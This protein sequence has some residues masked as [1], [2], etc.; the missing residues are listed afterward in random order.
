MGGVYKKSN[1]RR[2]YFSYKRDYT[3]NGVRYNDNWNFEYSLQYTTGVLSWSVAT[4]NR[5]SADDWEIL[6]SGAFR[7]LF[8]LFCA[9]DTQ[10]KLGW[11]YS[12]VKAVLDKAHYACEQAGGASGVAYKKSKNSNNSGFY[13][14]GTINYG[15]G[16]ANFTSSFNSFVN[17]PSAAANMALPTIPS[18]TT[19]GYLQRLSSETAAL[20]RQT[21]ILS[22]NSALD[23]NL[24]KAKKNLLTDFII[25]NAYAIYGGGDYYGK[26][27]AGSETFYP[28]I[29]Y[30]ST[31]GLLGNRVGD[32]ES[33]EIDDMI[34]SRFG[35]SRAG[36]LGN[37]WYNKKIYGEQLIKSYPTPFSEGEILKQK[38]YATIARINAGFDAL[39]DSW[40][41]MTN[42]SKVG[43]W[44]ASSLTN[45]HRDRLEYKQHWDGRNG[46]GED[47]KSKEAI[48]ITYAYFYWSMGNT[49]QTAYD[50]I[51]KEQTERIKRQMISAD[52]LNKMKC[53]NYNLRA[54]L[55]F[56]KMSDID[57][58][59][60]E[61]SGK[62]ITWNIPNSP[63]DRGYEDLVVD[64]SL[65]KGERFTLYLSQLIYQK[66]YKLYVLSKTNHIFVDIYK[67]PSTETQD[68][69]DET[70]G[71]TD[72]STDTSKE[73]SE[74]QGTQTSGG[75]TQET[76][77][78]GIQDGDLIARLDENGELM[79]AGSLD[80]YDFADFNK[81]FNHQKTYT[82]AEILKIYN[83]VFLANLTQTKIWKDENTELSPCSL[84]ITDESYIYLRQLRYDEFMSEIYL[85]DDLKDFDDYENIEI[86]ATDFDFEI[87]K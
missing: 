57:N 45:K 53:Y 11:S 35:Q 13:V 49:M 22:V 79:L 48:G 73:T 47:K 41:E 28:Q 19:N 52:F 82:G 9:I 43:Y 39:N 63:D 12:E 24:R 2:V 72:T 66:F 30:D 54:Q 84:K 37:V 86:N 40:V 51:L 18:L 17:A 34:C 15:A 69:T 5:Y 83:E 32:S 6:F 20:E 42:N 56:L 58:G 87:L 31:K 68:K 74:T 44:D 61:D 75:T 27:A 10:Y 7:K 16:G 81:F 21:Q 55:N 60:R 8:D 77:T 29:A 25:N 64:T 59:E 85:P 80:N 1:Y 62:T 26:G 67:K 14:G 33:E 4:R 70:Q 36:G 23:E 71:G 65:S 76:T 3:I 38:Y 50:R 46:D 78:S